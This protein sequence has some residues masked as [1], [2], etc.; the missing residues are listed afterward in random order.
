[1]GEQSNLRKN[2]N[3]YLIITKQVFQQL[4]DTNTGE[5]MFMWQKLQQS[6]PRTQIS[7]LLFCSSDINIFSFL[8][9]SIQK[10]LC[11]P[12]NDLDAE[13]STCLNYAKEF[14]YTENNSEQWKIHLFLL[15]VLYIY[16]LSFFGNMWSLKMLRNSRHGEVMKMVE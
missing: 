4:H 12:C 9:G 15:F 13:L 6:N 16:L 2:M 5:Q 3:K 10:T 14:T 1:M 7:C 11:L 8:W